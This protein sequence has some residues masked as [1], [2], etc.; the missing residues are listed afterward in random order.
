[1]WVQGESMP[2]ESLN[3]VIALVRLAIAADGVMVPFRPQPKT[4]NN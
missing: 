1:M 3:E 2:R 4:L